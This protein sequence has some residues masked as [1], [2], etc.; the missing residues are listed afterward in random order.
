[1]S[2]LRWNPILSEWL[3]TAT[4]RQDRP[5]MPTDWCPFCPGSGRVPESYDVHI[6]PNDF[7]ALAIPPRQPDV[8]GSDLYRVDL[9]IG[10]CDVVLYH[11]DHNRSFA[12]LSRTH[13]RR[14]IDTWENRFAEHANLEEV[15]YVF[16]FENK[17]EVIGVTMPHPHGQIYA[18]PIIPPKVKQKLVSASSHYDDCGRCVFCDV[19]REEYKNGERIIWENGHF[20][21]FVPFFARYPYEV[22]IY[23]KRHVAYLENMSDDEKNAFAD[24]LKI[25][26]VKYDNLFGFSFPYMKM[27]FQA[28]VDGQPHPYWH[29]HVEFLPPHRSANKL[30]YLASC[31]SG[32]GLFV[33]DTRIEENAAQ[34]RNVA[35]EAL[36]HA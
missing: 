13:I 23:P 26:T 32:T 5:Q 14:I 7:P 6:Y 12:E 33:N 22:H 30:K 24:A 29:F 3:A 1:M 9:G 27:I 20:S 2:E 35:V 16:I 31:E 11:P 34:L 17:G 18:L 21:A 15:N 19:L 36:H 25:V 10:A 28:P 4:H 8:E